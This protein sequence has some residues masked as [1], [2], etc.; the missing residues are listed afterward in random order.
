MTKVFNIYLNKPVAS[1]WNF[2][3]TGSGDPVYEDLKIHESINS[4]G[5]SEKGNIYKYIQSKLMDS[6]IIQQN[7][8]AATIN[9]EYENIEIDKYYPGVSMIRNN[10]TRPYYMIT[11]LGLYSPINESL[12]EFGFSTYLHL[13]VWNNEESQK[14]LFN[15]SIFDLY[16]DYIN[17][18]LNPFYILM[19]YIPNMTTPWSYYGNKYSGNYVCWGSTNTGRNLQTYYNSLFNNHLLS[20][21]SSFGFEKLTKTGY[22]TKISP[23]EIMIEYPEEAETKS[24]TYSYEEVSNITKEPIGEFVS[25]KRIKD[26]FKKMETEYTQNSVLNLCKEFDGPVRF[27]IADRLANRKNK[28]PGST[29]ILTFHTGIF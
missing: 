16:T 15:T 3:N 29:E 24:E 25:E 7:N 23:T 10:Q 14:N 21:M 11:P 8:S 26:A 20:L 1:L 19:N 9:T 13:C 27:L 17:Y 28:I 22:T 4:T 6:G 2:P 18:C 5:Y 12:Y